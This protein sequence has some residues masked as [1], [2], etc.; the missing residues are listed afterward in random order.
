MLRK[1]ISS[2]ALVLILTTYFIP[3]VLPVAQ[4]AI[5]SDDREDPMEEDP[6][7]GENM[8]ASDIRFPVLEKNKRIG[9]N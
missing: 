1:R 5:H 7:P 9:I 6:L 8:D 2:I 3:S 4:A